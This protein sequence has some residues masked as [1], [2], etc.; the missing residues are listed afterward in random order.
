VS[1]ASRRDAIRKRLPLDKLHWQP[2]TGGMNSNGTPDTYIDGPRSDLWI[3]WKELD[4]MPR[5]GIVRVAP[6]PRVKKQP[7]GHLTH[8]QLA[9]L[10]RRFNNA[11]RQGY[12]FQTNAAVVAFLPNKRALLMV[13]PEEWEYG[14]PV[15]GAITNEEL[16]EWITNFCAG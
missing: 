2:M 4:H 6:K 12:S 7:R 11:Q 1:E 8:L 5:D 3:E 16:A 9:W 13:T 15:A 10:K 14:A